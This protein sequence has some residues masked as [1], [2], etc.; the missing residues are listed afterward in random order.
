[1]CR[2]CLYFPPADII[3]GRC[4]GNSFLEFEGIELGAVFNLT[5]RFQTEVREGTLLYLDQ[6]TMPRGDFFIKLHVSSGT[7]QVKLH[8]LF[9]KANCL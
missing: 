5:V 4:S 8:A 9:F 6:G 1:M 3:V 7:L 2:F